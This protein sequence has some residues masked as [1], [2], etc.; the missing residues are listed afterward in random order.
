MGVSDTYM[1]TCTSMY[2]CVV[3]HHHSVSKSWRARNNFLCHVYV[4]NHGKT[5]K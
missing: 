2:I 4:C 5:N 3:F 1:L